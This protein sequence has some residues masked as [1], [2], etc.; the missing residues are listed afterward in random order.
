MSVVIAITGRLFSGRPIICSPGYCGKE[1]LLYH[2][3][4]RLTPIG[5]LYIIPCLP[6]LG[7][8]GAVQHKDHPQGSIYKN[9]F[10]PTALVHL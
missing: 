5:L 6:A 7:V 10:H 1:K 4:N 2:N 9:S 3:Q 8:F